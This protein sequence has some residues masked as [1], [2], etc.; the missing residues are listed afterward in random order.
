VVG[1]PTR[2]VMPNLIMLWEMAPLRGEGGGRVPGCG[3]GRPPAGPGVGLGLDRSPGRLGIPRARCGG[4]RGGQPA[5]TFYLAK[6]VSALESPSGP[7]GPIEPVYRDVPICHLP[8]SWDG[9][10]SDGARRKGS[11]QTLQERNWIA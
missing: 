5:V 9:S 8:G 2:P 4:R 10:L 1:S 6:K 3:Y 7:V 11:R